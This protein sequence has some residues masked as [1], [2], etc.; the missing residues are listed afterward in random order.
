MTDT[1]GHLEK[2]I[3]RE[4]KPLLS[5]EMAETIA[6]SIISKAREKWGGDRHYVSKDSTRE[7]RERNRS[8]ISEWKEQ[9]RNGREDRAK[10]AKHHNVHS[11]TVGRVICKYINRKK[12]KPDDDWQF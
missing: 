8:I 2:E 7:L 9:R 5:D 3:V 12:P 11:T 6:R 1:L 10:I 4:L